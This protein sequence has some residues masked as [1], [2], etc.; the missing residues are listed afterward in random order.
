MT[1]RRLAALAISC[2]CLWAGPGMG[3]PS[4]YGPPEHATPRPA[5]KPADDHAALRVPMLEGPPRAQ[6]IA[7]IESWSVGDGGQFGLGRFRVADPPRPPSNM[8][9]VREPIGMERQTRSI[10]GAGL[11]IRFR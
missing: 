3:Q 9:R 1:V 11:S 10:A 7:M 5:P 6:P 2:A 4:V 8:E